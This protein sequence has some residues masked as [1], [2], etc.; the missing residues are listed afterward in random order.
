MQQEGVTNSP[1]VTNIL[2]GIT[3]SVAAIKSKELI[4]G[5]TKQLPRLVPSL[6]DRQFEV[7]VVLTNNA[8]YF[9][10][11]LNEPHNN[12]EQENL[13]HNFVF[14]DSDEW[15]NS[16]GMFHRG[17]K[18]LHIELRKWAHLFLVAPLDANTLAK[19]SNGTCDNLL[20]CILRCWDPQKPLLLA[21]A[22]NTMMWEHPITLEQLKK[23]NSWGFN[24]TVIEPVSKLL[25]CGD[26]GNG[27]MESVEEIIKTVGK[28]LICNVL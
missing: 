23:I 20:T 8:K 14:Q 17:D 19:M 6:K 2:L 12:Q 21:P 1:S 26:F 15:N 9:T 10:S 4:D 24:L 3:G 13:L 7:K 25:A 16:S 22:M 27:A 11:I 28:I 5:L 18:V